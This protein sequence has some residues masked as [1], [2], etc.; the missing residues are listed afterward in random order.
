MGDGVTTLTQ[1][2]KI[3]WMHCTQKI[4]HKKQQVTNIIFDYEQKRQLPEMG[5]CY[6]ETGINGTQP[7]HELRLD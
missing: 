5:N 6:K 4:L 3:V 2:C 1:T 7:K